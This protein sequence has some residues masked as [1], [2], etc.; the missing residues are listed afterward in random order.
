MAWFPNVA[1]GSLE[2][3]VS[4]G[5]PGWET[6]YPCSVWDTIWGWSLGQMGLR[7][8]PGPSQVP[9]VALPCAVWLHRLVGCNQPS[10]LGCQQEQSWRV[11]TRYSSLPVGTMKGGKALFLW[12]SNREHNNKDNPLGGIQ[13]PQTSHKTFPGVACSLALSLRDTQQCQ[14]SL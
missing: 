11:P 3:D 10:A 1:C 12:R 9:L 2:A 8:L 4:H 7:N 5:A 6:E 13:N 14:L